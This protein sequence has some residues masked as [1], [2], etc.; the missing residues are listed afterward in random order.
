[1]KASTIPVV[2]GGG[3]M[4]GP[5][6]IGALARLEQEG[7]RARSYTGVSIGSV[8]SAMKVNGV[9][10]ADIKSWFLKASGSP[11]VILRSLVPSF[12]PLRY[13]GGGIA[14]LIPFMRQTVSRFDLKPRANLRIVAYDLLM[15]EPIIFE[16][17]DYDLATAIAA[18]CSVPLLFRPV[19]CR[20]GGRTRLLV[21]GGVYHPHPGWFCKSKALIIRLLDVPPFFFPMERKEDFTID[22]A[23][24]GSAFFTRLTESRYDELFEHGYEKASEALSSGNFR[25]DFLL[26]YA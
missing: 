2:V 10:D 22:A 12:N 6:A 19:P 24:P 11:A 16:G 14:D 23:M 21:D 20:I 26:A 17:E 9:D 3:A 15:R 7:I 1:M 18:S 8:I 4:R 5:A 13:L 25:E